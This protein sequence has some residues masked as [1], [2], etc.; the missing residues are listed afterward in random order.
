MSG[1]CCYCL[2]VICLAMLF[3]CF[4]VVPLHHRQFF[5]VLVALHSSLAPSLFC[6]SCLSYVS[7]ECAMK[8]SIISI[9]PPFFGSLSLSHYNRVFFSSH[10][11]PTPKC[12][13]CEWGENA[14]IIENQQKKYGSWSFIS[15]LCCAESRSWSIK[16]CLLFICGIIDSYR[17]GGGGSAKRMNWRAHTV[18]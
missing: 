7:C 13:V 2:Y 9:F 5:F 6:A 15:P 8:L 3:V 14:R 1:R 17:R 4:C 12:I 11:S 10:C 16:V 18:S